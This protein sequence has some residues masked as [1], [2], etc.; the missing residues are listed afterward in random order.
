MIAFGVTGAIFCYCFADGARFLR[1]WPDRILYFI[2]CLL[3]KPI[4]L[5]ILLPGSFFRSYVATKQFGGQMLKIDNVN[6]TTFMLAVQEANF[7][8]SFTLAA[9]SALAPFLSSH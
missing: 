1:T 2:S 9:F 4:L 3:Q 5:P 8:Y 6:L 7:L